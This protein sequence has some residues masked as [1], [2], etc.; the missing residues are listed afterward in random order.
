MKEILIKVAIGYG[1]IGFLWFWVVYITVRNEPGIP[2][3]GPFV[4]ALGNAV[5]WFVSI[6][7][8]ASL[9]FKKN[10]ISKVLNEDQQQFLKDLIHE[11]DTQDNRATS[12]PIP[13]VREKEERVAHPEY[14]HQK[15]IWIDCDGHE[16]IWDHDDFIKE[17]DQ[18]KLVCDD[19]S[20]DPQYEEGVDFSEF[21]ESLQSTIE[22][23]FGGVKKFR[24][25]YMQE[26][27]THVASFFTL[28]AA[29]RFIECNKHNFNQAFTFVESGYRNYEFQEIIRILRAVR[30]GLS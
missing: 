19:I 12:W 6:P 1:V 2:I 18:M 25:V 5:L 24:K 21:P 8:I 22:E 4:T 13:C 23:V 29:Y 26:V 30:K 27:D 15:T 16:S 10:P 3:I 17:I 7:W 11:L 20:F 9:H 28:K 14:D